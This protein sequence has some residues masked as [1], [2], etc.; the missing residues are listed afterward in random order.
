MLF[1]TVVNCIQVDLDESCF[2]ACAL[3]YQLTGRCL[4]TVSPKK[5]VTTFSTIT[6]TIS[7]PITIIFGIVSSKSRRHRKMVSFATSRI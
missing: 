3:G 1:F 5:H 6:L 7:V 4:Y 2:M